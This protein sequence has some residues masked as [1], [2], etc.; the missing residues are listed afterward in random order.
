M[1]ILALSEAPDASAAL[2]VAKLLLSPIE[3]PTEAFNGAFIKA[4][5]EA[6]I[7]AFIEAVTDSGTVANPC[8]GITI[9]TPSKA[10]S[11]ACDTPS[12]SR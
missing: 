5:V 4:F 8:D 9:E 1:G 7:E 3:A 2:D 11:N 6:F 10:G 12:T